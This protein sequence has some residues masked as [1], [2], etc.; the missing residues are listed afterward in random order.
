MLG[1]FVL[2]QNLPLNDI[3]VVLP[4]CGGAVPTLPVTGG[5]GG[6][7]AEGRMRP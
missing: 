2:P 4:G 5:E 6:V 1:F 3:L 7:G